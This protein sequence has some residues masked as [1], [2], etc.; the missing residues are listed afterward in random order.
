[1]DFNPAKKEL[2]RAKKC[3]NRMKE[4]KNYEEFEESWGDFLSRVENIFTKISLACSPNKR[5]VG[6]CSKTN[7]LRRTDEV[8]IYLKQARNVVHHGIHDTS[9]LVPRSMIVKAAD[10]TKPS[11]VKKMV[12]GPSFF[13]LESDDDFIIIF[14]QEKI[15]VIQFVNRGVVYNTPKNHLGKPLISTSPFEIAELGVEF[16]ENFLSSAEEFFK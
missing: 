8:L 5:F 16:Y 9:K 11:L 3:I 15:E 13:E 4:A 7:Q 10:K 6:F 1:M 14:N 2:A 12:I